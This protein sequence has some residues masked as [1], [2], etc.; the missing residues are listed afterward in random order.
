MANPAVGAHLNLYRR[1]HTGQVG[2]VNNPSQPQD[3]DQHGFKWFHNGDMMDE[4]KRK[5]ALAGALVC[6]SALVA[7]A[8]QAA[9]QIRPLV[10]SKEQLQRALQSQLTLNWRLAQWLDLTVRSAR[11]ELQPET[12]QV[13][14]ALDVNLQETLLKSSWPVAAKVALGAD[15]DA[16]NNRFVMSRVQLLSLESLT[17]PVSITATAKALMSQALSR[18]L[19]GQ[20]LYQ[21]RPSEIEWLA[22]SGV[23]PSLVQVEAQQLRL[24]LAP[25]N[26]M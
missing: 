1:A 24:V 26:A 14:L 2:F 15:F 6:A 10:I 16:R 7:C 23:Q 12:Q 11:V 18:Q 22:R 19:Q 13:V 20:T 8:S 21:L 17:L 5:W 25:R 4:S 3:N 9:L